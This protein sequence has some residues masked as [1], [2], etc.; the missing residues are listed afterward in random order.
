MPRYVHD[1]ELGTYSELRTATALRQAGE[2]KK[3]LTSDC[4][5]Y[6][7]RFIDAAVAVGER[8]RFDEN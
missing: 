4:L 1:T 7:I 6:G 5:G 8:W 3:D 2:G